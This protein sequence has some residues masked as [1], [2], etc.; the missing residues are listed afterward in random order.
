MFQGN[1]FVNAVYSLNVVQNLLGVKGASLESVKKVISHPQAL[2]QSSEFIAE[3]N[4]KTEDALN[5]AR[6][7]KQVADSG[8]ITV[9]AIA[10][11]ETA[12]LYG[13]KVL[14]IGRAHV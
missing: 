4:Y 9:A 5:T 8:D 1:L 11:E 12:S 10:S 7:A 14:E 2:E 13:L 3:H 6:A